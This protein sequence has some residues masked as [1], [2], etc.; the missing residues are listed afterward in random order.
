MK[1]M[2]A[3]PTEREP[4]QSCGECGYLVLL[5]RVRRW[6]EVCRVFFYA[7]WLRPLKSKGSE[8]SSRERQES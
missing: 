4:F 7:C 3:T 8:V 6:R 2:E 1:E 5:Y